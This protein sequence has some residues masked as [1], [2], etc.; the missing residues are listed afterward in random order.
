MKEILTDILKSIDKK[1]IDEK[2][3]H[4]NDWFQKAELKYQAEKKNQF[5]ILNSEFL[6]LISFVN[7]RIRTSM[8]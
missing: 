8:E 3:Q 6:L 7:D 2:P 4:E 1:I 5:Q